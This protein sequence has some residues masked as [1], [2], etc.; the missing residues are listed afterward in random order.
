MSRSTW[1]LSVSEPL[2]LMTS[3]TGTAS[4]T[5][6]ASSVAVTKRVLPKAWGKAWRKVLPRAWR[7]ASSR[8]RSRLFAAY[9]HW[10]FLLTRL[11]RGLA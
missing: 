5:S 8:K 6:E 2:D 7:K 11:H 3:A 10:G 4:T 1:P 9:R